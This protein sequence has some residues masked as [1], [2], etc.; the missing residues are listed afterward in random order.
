MKRKKLCLLVGMTG[1]TVA[2]VLALVLT[3]VAPSSLSKAQ[4]PGEYNLTLN[5][6]PSAL[7]SSYQNTVA[8]NV[9]TQFGNTVEL[10]FVNAKQLANGFAQLANHGKIHNFND[11]NEALTGVNGVSFT[12]SGSFTF[13]P[14]VAKGLLMEVAPITVSAGAGKV[15]VPNCDYFEIEAGDNGASIEEIDFSYSCDATAVDVRA[16]NGEYT[17]VGNDGYTYY[18]SIEDGE[19][20]FTSLD[21]E[22]NTLNN[23]GVV[24]MS[25]KTSVSIAFEG[26]TYSF[27]YDGHALTYSSKSGAYAAYGPEVSLNR[28]YIVDNFNQYGATGTGYVGADAKY[29][30]TGLRSQFY[31]DYYTGSSSGEIGGSGWPIMTSTDNTT[32]LSTKG[33]NGTKGVAFKFSNGSSMRYISMNELY[34]VKRVVGKGSVL[35]FWA[36]GAYTNTNFNTDHA[37]NTAMKVYAYYDSPLTPSN[38]TTVRETFDFTVQAGSTW[39]HFEMPLNSGRTYYGFGVY[40]Q[41]KSGSA[42]YVP[43]D[44]FEI[45]TASP[46]A[47][48][49][50]PVAVSSVSVSPTE[51]AMMAG[52][53]SQLTATVLPSDA[54]NKSV[55]WTSSNSN[56]AT[57]DSE[58][59]VHAVAGGNATITV[60]TAD[61]G[62]TATC[63]VT[64]SNPSSYYPSGTYKA[65]VSVSG[66]SADFVISFG[67][68]SNHLI[69]VLVSNQNMDATGVTYNS[70]TNEFTISTTGTFTYNPIS[71]T[72][73]NITG[74]Y[75]YANDQL[76]NINFSGSVKD[77]VSN[78]TLPKPT[79]GLFDCDGTTTQLRNVFKR[80]YR[81]TGGG[82]SEDTGN[83]DRIDSNTTEFVS[84][85]GAMKLRPFSG[86]DAYGFV[87]NSDFSPTLTAKNLHFWV[88][89][90]GSEDV[91]FREWVYKSASLN[92]GVEI[93]SLTAKKGQWTYCAMGFTQASLYNFTVSAWKKDG[94]NNV[95]NS[96]TAMGIYLTFD[97][98]YVF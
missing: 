28:V 8:S 45:Y 42:Q 52:G 41:Q 23:N 96:S 19:A 86:G 11:S 32:L 2:G 46:Y 5:S 83:S 73:G 85:T 14:A 30:T 18:L 70:S 78:L 84:G 51:L 63:A 48:Y 10:S 26:L 64:V 80:R 13:K 76:I 59:L 40:A 95:I 12:G 72:T 57:V 56:V 69:A 20:S 77:Y 37:S 90:P 17:G 35:S 98:V 21:K 62:Y 91:V 47:E 34:G 61:G 25:S 74:T 7:T 65:A 66:Y 71:F 33:R 82:W 89:N 6:A 92:G 9:E 4:S 53:N 94:S 81:S 44:D 15:A 22:L 54:T 50:A 29:T 93:G 31:A 27:S 38:Q 75:D 39:Q 68:E 36:R 97:N 16:A 3:H 88:Y 79:T 24:T 49:V 58:G 60:T 1:A 55:S 43:F 67:T 87:L